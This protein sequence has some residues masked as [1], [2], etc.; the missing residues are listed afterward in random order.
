MNDFSKILSHIYRYR[1][2][3]LYYRRTE[4][5]LKSG[6]VIPARTETVVI[7]LPDVGSCLSNR[8]EYDQLRQDYKLACEK[9]I[10]PDPDGEIQEF[11]KKIY[12][13]PNEF[14][15][16]VSKIPT[17]TIPDDADGNGKEEANKDSTVDSS[18]VQVVDSDV[19]MVAE[20]GKTNSEAAAD[21]PTEVSGGD[22]DVEAVADKPNPTDADAGPIVNSNSGYDKALPYKFLDFF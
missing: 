15:D 7:F 14:V 11:K 16:R 9:F 21:L 1:F 10:N 6:R 20:N 2:V 18:S 22:G 17:I 12:A 3:E 8:L 5:T 19:E 4:Q 13:F